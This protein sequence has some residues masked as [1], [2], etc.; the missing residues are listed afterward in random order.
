M[1]D[2]SLPAKHVVCRLHHVIQ[3]ILKIATNLMAQAAPKEEGRQAIDNYTAGQSTK[4]PPPKRSCAGIK[5]LQLFVLVPPC[6]LPLPTYQQV[7]STWKY[8]CANGDCTLLL[9]LLPID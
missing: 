6:L 2:A 9:C 5:Y 3:S 8:I 1:D 4:M 7:G